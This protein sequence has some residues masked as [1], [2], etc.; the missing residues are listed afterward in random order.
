MLKGL[1]MKNKFFPRKDEVVLSTLTMLV[2]GLLV[3]YG[4]LS[5]ADGK[6]HAVFQK[7][8]VHKK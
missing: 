1:E 2:V 6:E 7:N 8:G 3:Y 4:A 5:L